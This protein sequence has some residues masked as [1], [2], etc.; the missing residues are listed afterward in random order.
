[1]VAILRIIGDGPLLKELKNQDFKKTII[2]GPLDNKTTKN[3]ISKSELVITT[4]N[5]LKDNL[6]YYT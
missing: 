3:I 6:H 2:E 5:F 4:P 1:M